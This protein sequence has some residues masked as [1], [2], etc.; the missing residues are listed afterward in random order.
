MSDPLDD[1]KRIHE[2]LQEPSTDKCIHA[3]L[4]MQLVVPEECLVRGDIGAWYKCVRCG[5]EFSTVLKPFAIQVVKGK[6]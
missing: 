3:Q 1:A 2:S 4:Q 5:A 6:P